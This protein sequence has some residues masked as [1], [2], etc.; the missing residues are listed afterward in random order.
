MYLILNTTVLSLKDCSELVGYFFAEGGT[1]DNVLRI[2][3]PVGDAAPMLVNHLDEVCDMGGLFD[4]VPFDDVYLWE[5]LRILHKQAD[6]ACLLKD[7]ASRMADCFRT[8]ATVN[9][10]LHG[11][12]VVK[13]R[14]GPTGVL[15]DVI[16]QTVQKLGLPSEVFCD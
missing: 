9:V 8:S 16:Q 6:N 12:R 3:K 5:I 13:N 14:L 4:R 10:I 2:L 7:S 11:G 1:Y 15:C